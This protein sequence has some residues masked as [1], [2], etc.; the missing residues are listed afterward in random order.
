MNSETFLSLKKFVFWV[1]FSFFC[2]SAETKKNRRHFSFDH[3]NVANEKRKMIQK[4][5][6]IFC[7]SKKIATEIV[8]G[9]FFATK[10]SKVGKKD[11]LLDIFNAKGP[12]IGY[13]I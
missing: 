7:S 12:S 8:N 3:K 9:F 10:R 13:G 5:Q 4:K 6:K 1:F 2:V 11:H